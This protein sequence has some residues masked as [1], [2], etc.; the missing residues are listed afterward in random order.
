MHELAWAREVVLKPDEQRGGG[1]NGVSDVDVYVRR[2]RAQAQRLVAVYENLIHLGRVGF[3]EL[4]EREAALF[5]FGASKP[6]RLVVGF[7]YLLVVRASAREALG[8]EVFED[9]LVDV[10]EEGERAHHH[11][12]G[13]AGVAGGAREVVER[14]PE[15]LAVRLQLELA[16][17]VDD[18]AAL[19]D[20]LAVGFVGVFVEG[21]EDVELVARA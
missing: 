21:D 19:G 11:H 14:H 10:D 5:G 3:G 2:H 9:F 18:D 20:F 6:Q 4:A 16:G 17:V 15:A 13:G 1:R 7:D 12:V 8:H